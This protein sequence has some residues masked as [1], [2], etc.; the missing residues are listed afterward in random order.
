MTGKVDFTEEEWKLL[1]EAP[2]TAGLLMVTAD[3]GGSFKE[4]FAV[5]KAYVEAREQHGASQLL[6]EIASAKP[7]VDRKRHGDAAQTKQHHLDTLT[8]AIELLKA[9]ASSE[10]VDA[11]RAFV[12]GLCERV[13]EA[14]GKGSG[15]ERVSDAEQAEI[16]E[17]AGAL[18]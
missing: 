8:R 2:P 16:D 6:D 5:S 14:A 9:K 4:S 15:A 1:L 13:A 11:Y 3:K 10:D 17:I 12:L 18:A 7:V